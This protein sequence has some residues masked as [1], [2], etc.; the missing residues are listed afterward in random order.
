MIDPSY[1][2]EVLIPEDRLQQRISELGAQISRDYV[3]EDLLLL[4]VLKGSV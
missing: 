3:G 1:V 4:A 2:K